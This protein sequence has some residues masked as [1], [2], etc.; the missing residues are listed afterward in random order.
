M[1]G[2]GQQLKITNTNGHL[3]HKGEIV[4]VTK[5]YDEHDPDSRGWVYAINAEG[6]RSQILLPNNYEIFDDSPESVEENPDYTEK[7]PSFD[8]IFNKLN[9]RS[10]RT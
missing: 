9:E 7:K 1:I 10:S 4:T 3:F 5:L 6:N 2:I 8:E